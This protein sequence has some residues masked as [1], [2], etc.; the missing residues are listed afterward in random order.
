MTAGGRGRI[1]PALGKRSAPSG[2][3]FLAVPLFDIVDDYL[4]R[5]A[6]A[7]FL[8]LAVCVVGVWGLAVLRVLFAIGL[9]PCGGFSFGGSLWGDGVEVEPMR[10][11]SRVFEPSGLERGIGVVL[12]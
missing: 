3:P 4:G 10:F 11:R 9:V 12:V 2:R 1:H 6:R 8:A 5:D 7:A